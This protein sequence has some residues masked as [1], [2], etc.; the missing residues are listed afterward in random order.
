MYRSLKRACTCAASERMKELLRERFLWR[1]KNFP[2]TEWINR[3]SRW[4]GGLLLKC[5]MLFLATEFFL[6]IYFKNILK[7][8]NPFIEPTFWFVF[9]DAIVIF[10]LCA[11][12]LMLRTHLTW[13]IPTALILP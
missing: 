12:L 9:V 2:R 1:D 5:K 11:I 7:K 13:I 10:S 4:V 6:F 3:Q 8:D